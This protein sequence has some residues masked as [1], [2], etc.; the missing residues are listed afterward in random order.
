MP[1]QFRKN[2][3]SRQA[4]KNDDLLSGKKHIE[5]LK[6]IR[7]I[8]N[9]SNYQDNCKSIIIRGDRGTGKTSLLKI[10]QADSKKYNLIPISLCLTETN[11]NSTVNF[12]HS[13]YNSL[14]IVCKENKI[15]LDEINNAEISV[16]RSEISD[17]T[18]LL[19]FEFINKLIEYK[20]S[21]NNTCNILAEDIVNDL[22]LIVHQHRRQK[23]S[24]G[25][26]A[27]LAFFIDEAHLVFSNKEVLNIIRHLIQEEIGIVFILACHYPCDDKLLYQVFDR[28]ERAFTVYN[29]GYFDT[30]ADVEQFFKKSLESVEWKEKDFKN[31]INN[32]DKLSINIFKLTGGKPEW[33]NSIADEMFTK[34]MVGD[35]TKMR[36]NSSLLSKIADDLEKQSGNLNSN[37]LFTFDK[38]RAESVI[39]LDNDDFKWFQFLSASNSSSTC[40]DVYDTLKYLIDSKYDN[41]EKFKSFVL[42]LAANNILAFE[43]N[44]NE[45]DLTTIGFNINQN[46]DI[47]I[48]DR[49]YLYLGSDSEKYWLLIMLQTKSNREIKFISQ[50]PLDTLNEEIANIAGYRGQNMLTVTAEE[51]YIF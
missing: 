33:V 21:P 49:K 20:I 50:S 13:L 15:L 36:L 51:S 14:F 10:I 19:V 3:F 37:N 43:A 11:S 44:S 23:N 12:L 31:C 2:P 4:L 6:N 28:V 1:I 22:K 27:K 30:I 46:V 29:V 9:Y 45:K 40:R 38:R 35:D 48:L 47:D 26:N 7:R 42:Q 8:F 24:F 16:V 17:K 32:F 5:C 34:V 18:D 25:E 39:K 41:V